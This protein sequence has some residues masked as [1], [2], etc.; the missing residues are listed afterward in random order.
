M[1][2]RK[3]SFLSLMITLTLLATYI[4]HLIPSPIPFVPGIKL[5]LANAVILTLLY[6][7][8]AKTSLTVNILRIIL[9]SMLFSGFSSM[10]YALIGGILSFTIMCVAKKSQCF[11][12]IGVSV[13]GATAHNFAQICVAALILDNKNLFYYLPVLIIAGVIT[14]ILVGYISFCLVRY[15]HNYSNILNSHPDTSS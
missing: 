3:L 13:L 12:I 6:L 2:A 15:L 8:D 7:F 9:A 5:G 11:S 4:E 10:I 1:S 14:G